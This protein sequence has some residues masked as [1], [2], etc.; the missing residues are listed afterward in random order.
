MNNYQDPAI[1]NIGLFFPH[2]MPGSER[3]LF[4][5]TK[6]SEHLAGRA[7]AIPC[8]GVLGGG[9]SINMAMYSRAHRSDFDAWDMPGWSADDMIPYLK[10]V[11]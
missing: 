8:G 6:P 10:K 5:P 3:T 4:Y 7:L 11:C 2:I 1:V 9:S